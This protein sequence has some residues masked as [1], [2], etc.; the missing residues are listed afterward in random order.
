[1]DFDILI[2]TRNR[3]QSLRLSLPLML[4]QSR[5]PRRVIIV[6]SSD[7][8]DLTR[9]TVSRLAASSA[10]KVDFQLYETEPGTAYQRSF[11]L[12]HVGSPIAF[13][14]DDDSMWFPGVAESVL[15]IYERDEDGLIGAVGAEESGIAPSG[16]SHHANN[17]RPVTPMHKRVRERIAKEFSR[18]E[19]T[20]FP[21][22]FFIEAFDRYKMIPKPT[23]LPGEN[24]VLS[25]TMTGFRMSFRTEV[26]RKVGFD[27]ALGRYA[28]FEDHDA[29][30]GVL[31]SH[32]IARARNGLVFHQVSGE[33]RA[34]PE[35]LGIMHILNRAY[36]TFKHSPEGSLARRRLPR[37]C[38][39][40]LLR[41]FSRAFTID[42]RRR[43]LG[44]LQ[45]F[46]SMPHLRNLSGRELQERY[47]AVRN[48]CLSAMG[49]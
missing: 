18:V 6:D 10:P 26:I 32:A 31:D 24:A 27:E 34:S 29:C 39:Y 30:L 20:L 25:A 21:D 3:Q 8:H 28:L 23:W 37:F 40:K 7:D 46:S 41:Y 12:K 47:I 5:L 13:I 15:K 49:E 11:G 42:G 22:P 17:S 1:M 33:R 16:E 38:L 35:E 45:A 14:P 9:K 43:F 48:R 19:Y 36:I 2:A 44:A 4:S